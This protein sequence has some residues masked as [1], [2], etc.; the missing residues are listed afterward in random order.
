MDQTKL[1]QDFQ[2]LGGNYWNGRREL[3]I[4]MDELTG[5]TIFFGMLLGIDPFVPLER[6]VGAHFIN[7]MNVKAPT[8]VK[9]DGVPIILKIFNC[10]HSILLRMRRQIM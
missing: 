6:G 7:I 5:Q 10:N 3:K 8:S 2:F 1:K 9:Q 4:N